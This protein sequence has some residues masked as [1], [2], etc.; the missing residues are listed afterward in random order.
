MTN[1]LITLEGFDALAQ[2]FIAVT[3]TT[4]KEQYYLSEKEIVTYAMNLLRQSLFKEELLKEERR[5]QYLTL[6]AEFGDEKL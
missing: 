6:H 4:E 3:D 1:K 5:Q 2:S